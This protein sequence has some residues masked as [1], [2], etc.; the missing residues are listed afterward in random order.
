MLYFPAPRT[1]NTVLKLT[2]FIPCWLV[3]T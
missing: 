3:M 2:D 1:A